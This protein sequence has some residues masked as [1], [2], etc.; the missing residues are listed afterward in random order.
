MV[1]KVKESDWEKSIKGK[2]KKW[3]ENTKEGAADWA[4]NT[5]EA[6]DIDVGPTSK[7]N[8]KDGV[9]SAIEDNAWEEGTEGKGKKWLKNT[10]RGL[11]R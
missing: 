8:Y 10:K 3:A 6:Y 7:E 9:D 1:R 5:G 4:K 2:A 11:E